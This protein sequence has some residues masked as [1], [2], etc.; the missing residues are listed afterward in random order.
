LRTTHPDGTYKEASYTGCGCA[1][2][3]VV[4]LTD[5]MTRR[6]KVYSDV[7]GR[8]WKREVLNW[9][10]TVYSTTTNALN[11]RDQVTLVRQWAGTENGGAYQDT[12]MSYDGFG[13]LQSKHVPEQNTGTATVYAYNADDTV[14]SVADARGASATY[15]YNA[16]YLVTGVTYFAPTGI[17]AT[18]NVTFG[19]DAAGNRTSMTDGTGSK[20][21]VYDELSCMTSETRTFAGLTNSYTLNYA[22]NLGNEVTSISL[23]SWSQQIGYNYDSSGRLQAVTAGGFNT[24]TYNWQTQQTTYTPLANFATGITYRASGALKHLSHGNGAELNLQYN[25]RM[26]PASSQ[27]TNVTDDSGNAQTTIPQTFDY[28]ADG[29]VHHAYDSNR[30]VFDRAYE[31]NQ[32]GRLKEAYSGSQARGGTTNDGPYRQSW[33]YDAFGNLTG[34]T[35]YLWNNLLPDGPVTYTNNRNPNYQYDVGGN[36]TW[37]GN[38]HSYDAAGRQS[39]STVVDIDALTTVYIT[40]T[41]DGDGRPAKRTEHRVIEQGNGPTQEQWLNSYFLTSTVLGGAA[42]VDLY[43]WGSKE[44]LRVFAAGTILAEERQSMAGDVHWRYANP[45]TTSWVDINQTRAANR[46]ER[47]PLGAEVTVNPWQLYQNANYLLLKDNGERMFDEGDDPFNVDGGCSLDGLPVSCYDR[48]RRMENG[49][50]T[51]E[52]VD[53]HGNV[54]QA[55][56]VHVLGSSV[57]VDRWVTTSSTDIGM[58]DISSPYNVTIVDEDR[59]YFLTANDGLALPQNPTPTDRLIT[60]ARELHDQPNRNDCLALVDLLRTAGGLFR[61]VIEATSALGYVLTGST[62]AYELY[63]RQRTNDMSHPVVAFENNGFRTEFAGELYDNQVRHFMAGL[64]TGESIGAANGLPRMNAREVGNG[65]NEVADRNLNG[66]SVPLGDSLRMHN[67]EYGLN[68]GLVHS[69]KLNEVADEV[70]RKV[71]NP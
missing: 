59:G 51:V 8:P 20:S 58:H 66:I 30:N 47:D 37:D 62:S 14:Q 6:Q 23:P 41:Y 21:F 69:Q 34:R 64:L 4:T 26:L 24:W 71:C 13:R 5:E 39:G 36:I 50:A 1:G 57:W 12:T 28:Y 9:D 67:G 52:T 60:H 63:A 38:E 53:S 56:Q 10:G 43:D 3:E 40:Q 11:A 2:G 46:E 49:T 27:L 15:N 31:Y 22:Y 65:I 33:A 19:Y 29:R 32:A 7:L 55:N 68:P 17:T 45:A 48:D 61:S 42:I 54:S 44:K 16:R 35:N 25:D 70:R 18:P